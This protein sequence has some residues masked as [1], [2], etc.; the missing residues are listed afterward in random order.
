MPLQ[1]IEEPGGGRPFGSQKKRKE[2][3]RPLQDNEK[4][5]KEEDIDQGDENAPLQTVS[6]VELA[7]PGEDEGGEKGGL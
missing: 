1:A 5:A 3:A 6:L 4:R 7:E 2:L